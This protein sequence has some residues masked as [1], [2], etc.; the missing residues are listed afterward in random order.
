MICLYLIGMGVPNVLF[1]PQFEKK[2]KDESN[3]P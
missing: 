2:I 1:L 3:L